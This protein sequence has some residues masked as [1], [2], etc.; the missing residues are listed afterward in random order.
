MSFTI[1]TMNIQEFFWR[2]RSTWLYSW[3]WSG[4]MSLSAFLLLP[5]QV[6]LMTLWP[7]VWPFANYWD[8]SELK[9]RLIINRSWQWLYVNGFTPYYNP[10]VY[11]KWVV[12]GMIRIFMLI[13]L[14]HNCNLIACDGNPQPI[15][16]KG[17]Q[18]GN[19][20]TR[21]GSGGG[22]GVCLYWGRGG[23]Q[24]QEQGYC[25]K[26]HCFWLPFVSLQ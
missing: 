26:V 2:C 19:R 15:R 23:H 14:V 3:T 12:R 13:R 7:F 18:E 6:S 11:V 20:W 17:A 10:G 16:F 5:L 9:K 4:K 1:F 24:I 8:V 21:G 22:V 25:W